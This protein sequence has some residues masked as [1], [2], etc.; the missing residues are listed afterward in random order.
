MDNNSELKEIKKENLENAEK[1]N[2][3]D[4]SPAQ[5]VNI[6]PQNQ[7]PP[8]QNKI[9]QIN[10]VKVPNKLTS[11]EFILDLFPLFILPFA[12]PCL[13]LQVE[14]INILEERYHYLDKVGNSW[15]LS[16]IM[17]VYKTNINEECQESDSN[18]LQK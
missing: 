2:H 14:L 3:E 4:L 10:S 11:K 12:I 16:P 6:K 5:I 8:K 7:V 18:I 1:Q 15:N 17:S 9:P 13:I